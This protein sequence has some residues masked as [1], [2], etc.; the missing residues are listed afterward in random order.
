MHK[1]KT[2]LRRVSKLLLLLSV[3]TLTLTMLTGCDTVLKSQTTL[4]PAVPA[5]TAADTFCYLYHPVFTRPSDRSALRDAVNV[6]NAIWLE[7]GCEAKAQV[8]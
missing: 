5:V 8:N 3:F 7:L 2:C 6:N 1:Q 4:P